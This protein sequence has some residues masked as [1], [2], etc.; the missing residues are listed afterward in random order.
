MGASISVVP[1]VKR[2]SDTCSSNNRQNKTPPT[3]SSNRKSRSRRRRRSDRGSSS[4]S[5]ES[6]SGQRCQ[7]PH[8]LERTESVYRSPTRVNVSPAR[9]ITR[10]EYSTVIVFEDCGERDRSEPSDSTADTGDSERTNYSSHR[11]DYRQ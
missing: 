3:N 8:Q 9:Y 11:N 5:K 6:E 1:Y 4:S 2:D 10:Q 7:T